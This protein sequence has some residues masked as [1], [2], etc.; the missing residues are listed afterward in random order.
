MYLSLSL[1]VTIQGHKA[2][3]CHFR[4]LCIW[5][6]IKVHEKC[7]FWKA[8]CG[9]PWNWNQDTL[10]RHPNLMS[11]S[12]G[13]LINL[14]NQPLNFSFFT[15]K[16]RL[17]LAIFYFSM[18]HV[19]NGIMPVRI[20]CKLETHNQCKNYYYLKISVAVFGIGLGNVINSW[21]YF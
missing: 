6:H 10:N 19:S 4:P 11:E 15:W 2:S 8:E 14:S 5:Y 18:L 21:V 17:I 3:Y 9:N 16:M 7:L 20:F 1:Q 12:H 13:T